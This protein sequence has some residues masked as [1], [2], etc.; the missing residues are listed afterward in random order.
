MLVKKKHFKGWA[1]YR[2]QLKKKKCFFYGIIYTVFTIRPETCIKEVNRAYFDFMLTLMFKH[3]LVL[4]VFSSPCPPAHIFPAWLVL[5]LLHVRTRLSCCDMDQSGTLWTEPP[6]TCQLLHR[7][8]RPTFPT[9]PLKGRD[10]RRVS[11]PTMLCLRAGKSRPALQYT[12]NG[13]SYSSTQIH[14]PKNSPFIETSYA[15]WSVLRR[16]GSDKIRAIWTYAVW[17]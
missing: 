4:L 6:W 5:V 3:N 14:W 7:R 17:Y 16:D 12:L 15:A 13:D 8:N 11:T 2:K 1:N 9:A 10:Y